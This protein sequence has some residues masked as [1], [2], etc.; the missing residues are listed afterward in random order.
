V[1]VHQILSGSGE[2]DAIT[3]EAR[4][5][6]GL[7]GAWGWGGRDF[8]ARV[9]RGT[10]SIQPIQRLDPRAEDVLVLHHSASMP[11]LHTLLGLPA[12]KLLVYHNITPAHYLWEHAPLVASQ[13]AVGRAQLRDLIAG[14]DA[15]AAHSA[16]NARELAELGAED[17]HVIPLFVDL[18]RLGP[19]A[20]PRASSGPTTIL[21][22]GRLSPHK[23]HAELIRAFA[24]YR[25]YRAADARLLL[26]GERVSAAYT[27]F[28]HR[29]ADD[30]APGAITIKSGLSDR[31][32]G[33]HYRAAGAF[34]CL[35]RHEGFCAPILEAF[36]T[37]LP[38]IARPSGA[39]PEVVGDAAVLVEDADP[40]V[41]A[42]LIHLVV[43]DAELR[44]ELI[45]RGRARL[46]EFS[47][48]PMERKLRAAVEAA[49]RRPVVRNRY[50]PARAV[51]RAGLG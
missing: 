1:N 29:L 28:L 19:P 45:G 12:A 38:V 26:V 3:R 43:T 40:A 30:L 49:A 34:A 11:G 8:A 39:I 25:Q 7:F 23:G 42:E 5:L 24:L 18:A 44:S 21:F 47:P 27:E 32:L 33:E 35:S 41:I 37:G 9:G 16:F 36:H 2:H 20:Q 10:P 22:I 14:V 50:A 15:T 46:R 13:C 48:E 17:T 4:Q 31:E 6:R 51:G